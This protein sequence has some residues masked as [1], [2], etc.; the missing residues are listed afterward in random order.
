VNRLPFD[1]D[2]AIQRDEGPF[3]DRSRRGRSGFRRSVG[4]VVAVAV[5]GAVGGSAR[6]GVDEM[7][8][9]RQGGFPWGTFAV[10]VGGAF[11][12]AL[13]LVLVL[14][15]WRPTRY[16]SP[17]LAVGVL[18]SFTTFSTLMV[19]VDQLFADGDAIMAATYLVASITAGLASTSAG[20]VIGRGI[21]TRRPAAVRQEA[22]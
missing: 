3:D 6:Y 13:L 15:V 11:L 5:G 10:N 12:L 1:P 4:P 19:D 17:L 7:V 22:R 2:L 14:D 21:S 8:P 20:L 16:V 9:T 18:G